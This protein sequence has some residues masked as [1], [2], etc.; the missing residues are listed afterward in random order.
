MLCSLYGN[1]LK[2]I[3]SVK[4]FAHF[5]IVLYLSFLITFVIKQYWKSDREENQIKAGN[6][7]KKSL[8]FINFES[9]GI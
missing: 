3:Y 5:Y 2:N 1:R 8:F 6:F 4:Y 9:F 7:L